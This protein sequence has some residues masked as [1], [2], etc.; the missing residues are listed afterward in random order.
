MRN[1]SAT[2]SHENACPTKVLSRSIRRRSFCMGSR[3]RLRPGRQG[4]GETAYVERKTPSGGSRMASHGIADRSGFLR[5]GLL[6]ALGEVMPVRHP[7]V[8][9]RVEVPPYGA[10]GEPPL[11]LGDFLEHRVFGSFLVGGRI[12]GIQLALQQRV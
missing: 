12:V 6:A 4:R 9:V 11:R 2:M 7:A 1:V 8:D 3:M 10:L 5:C